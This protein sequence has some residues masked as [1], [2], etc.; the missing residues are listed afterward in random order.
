MSSYACLTAL[1][2][3]PW[4]DMGCCFGVYEEFKDPR[5]I[6]YTGDDEGRVDVAFIL[7]NEAGVSKK[8]AARDSDLCRVHRHGFYHKWRGSSFRT[9]LLTPWSERSSRIV[10]RVTAKASEVQEKVA[11]ATRR[12][13]QSG[14]TRPSHTTTEGPYL[15]SIVRIVGRI[16]YQGWT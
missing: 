10:E 1:F 8:E 14:A 9:A 6:I 16:I 4:T 15:P 13:L 3:T 2:L 7:D 12:S 11:V 5:A